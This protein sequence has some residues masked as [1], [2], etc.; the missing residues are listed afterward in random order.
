MP[1]RVL[2]GTP[3]HKMSAKFSCQ[4]FKNG[5]LIETKE[6]VAINN[7]NAVRFI[8]NPW[9]TIPRTRAKEI[10]GVLHYDD[11]KGTTIIATPLGPCDSTHGLVIVPQSG[12]E[13]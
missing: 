8:V 7:W 5:T 6:V 10:D 3:I 9:R 12:G 2:R 11:K 4:V 1:R 13:R